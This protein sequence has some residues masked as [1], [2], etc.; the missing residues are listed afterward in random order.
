MPFDNSTVYAK[1]LNTSDDC[2]GTAHVN[3]DPCKDCGCCPPGL[4]EQRD[5]EGKVIGCLTPNDSNMY[6]NTTYKCPDGYVRLLDEAGN[7]QGCVS[8]EDYL[9]LNPPA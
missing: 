8:V 1:Y 9:Q 6:M 4:V 7:F 2:G 5:A 3:N